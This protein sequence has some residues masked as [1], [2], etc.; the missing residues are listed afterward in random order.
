MAL[1]ATQMAILSYQHVHV[2]MMSLLSS[3]PVATDNPAGPADNPWRSLGE[4][5]P[6]QVHIECLEQLIPLKP[7]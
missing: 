6:L 1:L 4:P 5:W 7:S 2:T 3:S